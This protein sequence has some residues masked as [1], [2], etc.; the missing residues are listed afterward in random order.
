MR[1]MADP[2][3]AE[4][5]QVDDPQGQGRVMV[6]SPVMG[7]AWQCWALVL[8]PDPA[9]PPPAYA[10]G[11]VVMIVF[12]GGDPGAPIVLGTLSSRVEPAGADLV[13]KLPRTSYDREDLVVPAETRRQL[14]EVI[15][16][17]KLGA[18]QRGSAVLFSG[19]TGT[20]KTMAA[21]I[22]ARE[23]GLDLFKV[24]LARVVS[25]YIGETEKNLHA[26]FAEAE[27]GGAILFFDEADALF[28]KRSEVKDSHD[29]YANLDVA[30]L[31]QR[32]EAHQGLVILATNRKQ[33]IDPAF[34]LRLAAI[35]CFPVCG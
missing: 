21:Q 33:E 32:I 2:I 16:T 25:K 19:P 11:D 12:E 5:A 20:G 4:I 23:L 6:R 9:A 24:D 30:W 27:A 14:D 8:R 29:R 7:E 34:L 28:G 26:V 13:S 22:M 31:L 3:R 18:R 15:A 17:A 10:P 35:V 1:P